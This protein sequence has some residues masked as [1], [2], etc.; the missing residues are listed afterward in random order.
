[1]FT[2]CNGTIEGVAAHE[3]EPLNILN[4]KRGIITV[5][6]TK[7]AET[8]QDHNEVVSNSMS[9]SRTTLVKGLSLDHRHLLSNER[10][11]A[12][13]RKSVVD[14]C[15]SVNARPFNYRYSK[16]AI[17]LITLWL[18]FR[19]EPMF[20]AFVQ[21]DMI[22]IRTKYNLL[23]TW[24]SATFQVNETGVIVHG[25]CFGIWW[26]RFISWNMVKLCNHLFHPMK[27]L[28]TNIYIWSIYLK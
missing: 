27:R 8:S 6:L 10:F 7:R 1:M 14:R 20:R 22:I 19:W 23:R 9:L 2:M 11:V 26:L 5:L 13:V 4:I 3:N 16:T 24:T 12:V 21:F 18:R 25:P 28:S 15:R 17:M